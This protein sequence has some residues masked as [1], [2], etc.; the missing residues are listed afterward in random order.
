M[1]QER[2]ALRLRRP[3][4]ARSLPHCRQ[5]RRGATRSERP[6][7]GGDFQKANSRSWPVSDG[8]R[9]PSTATTENARR[10][11]RRCFG[12]RLAEPRRCS[13]ITCQTHCNRTECS[14]PSFSMT[15]FPMNSGWRFNISQMRIRVAVQ[16]STCH[17]TRFCAGLRLAAA[18][19]DRR[20]KGCAAPAPGTCGSLER[21]ARLALPAGGTRECARVL[22]DR[23]H[24]GDHGSWRA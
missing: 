5:R 11:I 19:S 6:L 15:Y 9:T 7:C 12:L 3:T 18:C 20:W 22:V 16:R 23:A 8:H 24:G 14:G 13:L 21:R 17:P 10:P 4:A 1:Y 2:T